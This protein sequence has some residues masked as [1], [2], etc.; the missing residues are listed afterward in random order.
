MLVYVCVCVCVCVQVWDQPSTGLIINERLIN[1]PPQLAPPLVQALF[2]EV[3]WATED[4]PTQVSQ[5]RRQ[6]DTAWQAC[7]GGEDQVGTRNDVKMQE[8]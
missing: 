1:S 6:P 2:N 5:H 8:L 7:V 4:E 3:A